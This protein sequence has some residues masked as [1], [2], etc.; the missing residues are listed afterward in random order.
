MKAAPSRGEETVV[1]LLAAGEGRRFGA[2]KQL[3]P[4]EGEPMVHRVARML[5]RLRH[6]LLVVTGAG[7]D[8]VAAAL[9]RL[10]VTCVPNPGWRDGLGASLGA[11]IRAV[12]ERFP[13]ASAALVCLADHPLLDARALQA[14]LER[15]AQAPGQILAGDH[16]GAP[17]PPVLVPADGFAELATWHGAEGAQR[18]LYRQGPRVER[19]H[20]DLTDVDTREDLARVQQ[21]LTR[22]HES[23]ATIASRGDSP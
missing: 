6:P 1:V 15:H 18:W 13:R 9:A 7:G 11:G 20:L 21:A 8:A 12:R 14:M 5:L 10:P 2:L 23:P 3:A 22:P 19:L 16:A 4:I 17:G